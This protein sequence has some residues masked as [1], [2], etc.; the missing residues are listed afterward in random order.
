MAA[1][2]VRQDFACEHQAVVL[3]KTLGCGGGAGL[4]VS[5]QPAGAIARSALGAV[6][7]AQAEV[8]VRQMGLWRA[9]AAWRC[10]QQG[11]EPRPV[12]QRGVDLPGVPSERCGQHRRQMVMGREGLL[13]LRQARVVVPVGIKNQRVAGGV[14]NLPSP[15]G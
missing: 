10:D 3:L 6:E 13:P 1:H 8:E 2:A 4:H 9:P 11:P 14:R 15:L 12:L 7:V 5:E